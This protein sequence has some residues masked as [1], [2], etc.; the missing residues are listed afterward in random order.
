VLEKT[1]RIFG[2]MWLALGCGVILLGTI[3][4]LVYQGLGATLELFSP[5]NVGNFILT[6]MLVGPGVLMI[7]K[8]NQMKDRD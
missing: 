8:A 1:L 7:V 3:G 2:Y 5:F 6:M 4:T